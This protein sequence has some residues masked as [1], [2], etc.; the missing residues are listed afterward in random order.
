M[1]LCWTFYPGFTLIV[2][3]IEVCDTIYNPIHA[4][5]F[6]EY[7]ISFVKYGTPNAGGGPIY[8]PPFG[9]QG[10][11]LLMEDI[12]PFRIAVDDQVPANRCAFWECAPYLTGCGANPATVQCTIFEDSKF[13]VAPV[14][15]DMSS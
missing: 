8:W 11:I 15:R 14:A 2:D 13:E 9:T 4:G 6:H 5:Y 7:L 1:D 10:E 3:G 12:L